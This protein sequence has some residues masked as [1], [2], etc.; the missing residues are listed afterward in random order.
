MARAFK[1]PMLFFFAKGP[2]FQNSHHIIL[3]QYKKTTEQMVRSS[4]SLKQSLAFVDKHKC[5]LIRPSQI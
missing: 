2:C 3:T 1:I 4:I 5:H